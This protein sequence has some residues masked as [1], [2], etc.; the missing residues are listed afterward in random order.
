MISLIRS[1]KRSND[2]LFFRSFVRSEAAAVLAQSVANFLRSHK[3]E[4]HTFTINNLS[5]QKV[6]FVRRFI[7][8]SRSSRRR[9]ERTY[10][11]C[12]K[13]W[14]KRERKQRGMW[15][16]IIV[17]VAI[18]MNE[19]NWISSEEQMRLLHKKHHHSFIWNHFSS[20]FSLVC[21]RCYY[22]F[23]HRERFNRRQMCE[24]NKNFSFFD[25]FASL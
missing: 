19:T 20:L 6:N 12:I 2:R 13:K 7:T 5:I 14:E 8:C 4:W 15:V 3:S 16:Y 22:Y 17:G 10:I 1:K 25:A 9:E 23:I 24:Y 21:C 11:Q 18:F